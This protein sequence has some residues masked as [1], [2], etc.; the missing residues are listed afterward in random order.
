MAFQSG[1]STTLISKDTQIEGDIRFTGDLEIQ[2]L[3]R[4]SI[5]AK[6]DSN[7]TV[8]VVE[9][10]C[11]EGEIHAPKVIVNGKVL[12]DV[13]CSEHVELAAKATVDGDVYYQLI[14]M[15]KGSQ[16]NGKLLY[17]GAE[18]K[19][20]VESRALKSQAATS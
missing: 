2:G 6:P 8:R 15:V 10:G 14:E 3:V 18:Q 12:G 20:V 17:A 19:A 16:I 13:H 5:C 1:N 7:G 11:V 9:G 4:G